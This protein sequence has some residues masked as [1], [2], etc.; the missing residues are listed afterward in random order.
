MLVGGES[1]LVLWMVLWMIL[2]VGQG[3]WM[4]VGVDKTCGD[5]DD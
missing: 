3:L 1:C 2:L 5:D 4:F